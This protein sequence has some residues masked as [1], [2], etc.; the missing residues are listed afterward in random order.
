MWQIPPN[1]LTLTSQDVHLWKMNLNLSLPQIDRRYQMLSSEEQEK[2]DRFRFAVHRRRFIVARSTLRILLGRYVNLEPA[3]IEFTYNARGKPSLVQLSNSEQ[4]QFNLSHSEELAL[5]GVSCDRLIGVDLEHLRS[6][7]DAQSLAKRFFCRSEFELIDSLPLDKQRQA[8]F[9]MWTAK[10]AY[11][12]AVGEGI[13][14]GLNRVEVCFNE[15][16]P[17]LQLSDR[18][19]SLSEWTLL[20]LVPQADYLAALVVEG[21]NWQL[22][23]FA[24]E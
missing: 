1:N 11:L 20:P 22:R 8:F 24:L 12:K 7:D 6:L 18:S 3:Q 2:A 9:Q 19:T 4:L 10:E 14:G 16:N 15:P 21:N 17:F 5:Y 13:G 23:Q